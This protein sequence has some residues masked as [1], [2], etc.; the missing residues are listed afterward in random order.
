MVRALLAGQKT[1][2][3]RLLKPQPQGV[4]AG[5]YFDRYNNGRNWNFWTHDDKMCLGVAG[6]IKDTCHWRC[7]Y[8]EI[9]DLLYVREKFAPI[10]RYMGID[11][12]ADALAA[13]GFYAA[14]YPAGDLDDAMARWTPSILMPRKA[15]RLTLRVYGVRVER[16]N[17]I[18]EADS[19]AEGCAK[20]HFD[21]G[22][23]R[24]I[25]V[26]PAC[27]A[28]RDLWESINGKGSWTI[29]PWVWVVSFEVIKANVSKVEA[30]F[31]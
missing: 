11:P 24:G 2:T 30:G 5:A 12:G 26:I 22:E 28:Y 13:G 10:E 31:A 17:D 29:N 25:D 9:G 14:D 23:G 4:P 16:L 18:S 27:D 15:A 8:G 21:Y 1:Q 19:M 20:S 3:R 7:P 6:A